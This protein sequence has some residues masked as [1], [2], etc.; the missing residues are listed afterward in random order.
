MSLMYMSDS[1]ETGVG[2][3][4]YIDKSLNKKTK[5][6]TTP[7]TVNTL[8]PTDSLPLSNKFA[9]DSAPVARYNAVFRKHLPEMKDSKNYAFNKKD[10]RNIK[11]RKSSETAETE[12]KKDSRTELRQKLVLNENDKKLNSKVSLGDE[13][14]KK[15]IQDNRSI[16]KLKNDSEMKIQ[17]EHKE[18]KI[19]DKK[20]L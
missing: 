14:F 6:S 4:A 3:I 13:Q 16:N 9:V 1:T 17:I 5:S 2:N 19:I 18:S 12:T 15:D 8:L 7:D 10:N 11:S 20:N